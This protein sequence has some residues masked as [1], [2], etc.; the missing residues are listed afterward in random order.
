VADIPLR[1]EEGRY[2]ECTEVEKFFR[3]EGISRAP[4]GAV[5]SGRS[6]CPRRG[7]MLSPGSVLLGEKDFLPIG[8]WAAKWC[9]DVEG[10]GVKILMGWSLRRRSGSQRSVGEV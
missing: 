4:G 6:D 2:L 10:L 3:R 5:E 1:R 8:G 7:D 9:G